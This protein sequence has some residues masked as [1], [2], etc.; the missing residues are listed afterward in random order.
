MET[1]S[2]LEGRSALSRTTRLSAVFRTT[3]ST[4]TSS[5][6]SSVP[7]K[8]ATFEEGAP[9]AKAASGPYRGHRRQAARRLDDR[10]M[11]A[12]GPVAR[13]RGDGCRL[14]GERN[15]GRPMHAGSDS[16]LHPIARPV[17]P[18]SVRENRSLPSSSS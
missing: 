5:S 16:P 4:S 10:K 7:L 18:T 1:P 15:G 17:Y 12:R 8:R 14:G 6:L 3:H 11:I 2:Q 9:R 13:P